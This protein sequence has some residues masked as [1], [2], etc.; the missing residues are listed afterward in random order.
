MRIFFDTN[1]LA[2]GLMGHGLCRDLLDRVI[3]EHEVLLGDPVHKELHRI[4]TSKFRVPAAL[5][6]ELDSKLRE[7]EHAPSAN[8]PLNT[9]VPDP[10][11]IPI[12]AC[13]LAA[14][15]DAFITGDKVLL[16]LVE[17]QGMPI[18]S[19]R[20]LWQKLTGLAK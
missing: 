9:P 4:L 6:R 7:F 15:T 19:P 8:N 2:S 14:K 11:D 20:Q 18:L 16:D 10:D 17:V 13:A 5:W 1:V 12:L 3:I